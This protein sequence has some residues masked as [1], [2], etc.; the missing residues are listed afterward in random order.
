[1]KWNDAKKKKP[2]HNDLVIVAMYRED[3]GDHMYFIATWD[4]FD[5]KK[6]FGQICPVATLREMQGLRFVFG[7]K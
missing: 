6:G 1:M 4:K 2:R 7:A 5:R 3:Q